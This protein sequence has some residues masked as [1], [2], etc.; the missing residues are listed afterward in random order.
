MFCANSNKLAYQMR[1]M[2]ILY[3]CQYAHWRF[4]TFPRLFLIL[5]LTLAYSPVISVL[6][7]KYDTY[8]GGEIH[9]HKANKNVNIYFALTLTINNAESIIIPILYNKYL[10]QTNYTYTENNS[11]GS[12]ATVGI[13]VGASAGVQ[14]GQNMSVTD[15]TAD[16]ENSSVT[17][18]E[19]QSDSLS[20]SEA[21]AKSN[22]KSHTDGTNSSKTENQSTSHTEGT[23]KTKC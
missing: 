1:S 16:T 11:L 13:N 3:F 12:S 4:H 8:Q 17:G 22:S 21:T 6:L 19:S 10:P 7:Y 14:N 2:S 20:S 23:N 15:F 9:R 18:T 5:L